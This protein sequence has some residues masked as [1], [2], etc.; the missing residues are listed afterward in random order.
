MISFNYL[1]NVCYLQAYDL[2]VTVLVSK[3]AE[4]A[5]FA[6]LALSFAG[7]MTFQFHS[8]VGVCSTKVLQCAKVVSGHLVMSRLWIILQE[9]PRGQC[10]PS[11]WREV[12]RCS[13]VLASLTDG[14]ISS[15]IPLKIIV[16]VR[17]ST[18]GVMTEGRAFFGL[19]EGGPLWLSTGTVRFR[20]S[21]LDLACLTLSACRSGH[22]GMV[23]VPLSNLQRVLTQSLRRS[24]ASMNLSVVM[25]VM[26]PWALR[27]IFLVCRSG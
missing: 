13:A 11:R 27:D 7:L 22:D 12:Q 14:I 6:L 19:L 4:L 17:S 16:P 20:R 21:S 10:L 2:R 15:G 26:L 3:R 5:S 23:P 18:V 25:S 1:L 8:R 9:I 24:K